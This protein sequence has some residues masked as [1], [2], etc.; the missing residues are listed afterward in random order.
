MKENPESWVA[1]NAFTDII[2]NGSSS[3][4]T[5][6]DGQKSRINLRNV[7]QVPDLRANLLSVGKITDKSYRAIFD[8]DCTTVNDSDGNTKLIALLHEL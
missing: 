7:L 5:K 8:R 1:T 6:I 4:I 3:I 2:V